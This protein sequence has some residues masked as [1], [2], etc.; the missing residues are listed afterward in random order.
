M[1]FWALS[2]F[3]LLIATF[4]IALKFFLAKRIRIEFSGSHAFVT[5][6]SKGIG[7]EI[8]IELVRRGCQT[9]SIA[10][11]KRKDLEAAAQVISSH[12]KQNQ[13]VHYYELDVSTDYKTIE[14]VI[15][16]AVS[17]S[18][19][20]DFL[21]NNA[22]LVAQG[23]FDDL[24]IESFESQL[25]INYLSAVYTTRAVVESMKS[26]RNGHITFVSSA[27]GQCAIWGYTA[28]SPSKF[29][30]RGFAEALHMELLP[31]NIGVSILF[32]PN[33]ETE[34][35]QEEL[36][37]MPEEVKLISGTAGSFSPKVVAQS[38]VQNIENGEFATTIGFEGWML[39]VLT[40]GAGP[41]PSIVNAIAQVTLGSLLRGIM[42]FYIGYF[43]SLVKKCC[44][45]KS[46][47]SE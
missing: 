40:A 18:G 41:E 47:K 42:L 2:A 14:A 27:A 4:F 44:V 19:P 21:V 36:K 30:I 12:C 10:A 16:K 38:V 22:G 5:G 9:V 13:K 23:A 46:A 1:L 33:T 43:N 20:I 28:Y 37:T 17:E 35:F 8:A 45:K 29:A 25:K 6:G 15:Q 34:G 3:V 31:Y 32:P 26:R 24:P 7:K 39:G 11:R